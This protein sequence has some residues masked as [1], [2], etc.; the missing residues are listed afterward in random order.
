M[1]ESTLSMQGGGFRPAAPEPTSWGPFRLIE[2]VG[3][4][5]FGQVYR[6]WDSTLEREVALKLLLPRGLNPDEE[7]KVVLREARLMARVRHPNVVPV[8]GVDRHEGRVGFWSDFVR[9]K[10]LSALL[11]DQGPFGYR[12][13]AL[14]GIELGKA[15]SAVHA[16]GLLHRDIKTGNAM[17][18]EGGRILLMDFGLTDE[19]DAVTRLG[20]TPVYLAPEILAGEPASVSSDIYA[21]GVLLYRLLTTKYPVGGSNFQELRAAHDSGSRRTLLDER[22]DRPDPFVHVIETALDR[23]PKKRFATAGQMT[24]ALSA[25]IGMSTVSAEEVVAA[26]SQPTRRRMWLLAPVL[27]VAAMVLSITPVRNYFMPG[28]SASLPGAGAH[29]DYLKPR[30]CSIITTSRATSRM[31]FRFSKKPSPKIPGLL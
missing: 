15:V 27:A 26:P 3:Q 28:K 12:E 20:G 17:R 23:D 2:K 25:A 22:P 30:I 21:L 18:E 7:A 4:G 11:A 9:G 1:D 13:A 6:A 19:H 16:A 24:A 5:A 14:I 31:P 29:A 8:Y 10:T